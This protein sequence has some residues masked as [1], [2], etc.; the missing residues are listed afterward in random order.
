MAYV[1]L[2]LMLNNNRLGVINGEPKKMLLLPSLIVQLHCK[3]QPVISHLL[4]QV[5]S[6]LSGRMHTQYG[7]N[8]IHK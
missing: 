2:C 1:L 4:F 7:D 3:Q 6:T 5:S 8:I